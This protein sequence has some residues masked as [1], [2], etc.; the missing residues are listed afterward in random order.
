MHIAI[1]SSSF[2]SLLKS[3]VQGYWGFNFKSI[4]KTCKSQVII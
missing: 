4:G 1:A 3:E 2:P